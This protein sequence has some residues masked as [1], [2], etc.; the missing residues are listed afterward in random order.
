MRRYLPTFI[1]LF[2]LLVLGGLAVINNLGT[3]ITT[4]GAYVPTLSADPQTANLQAWIFALAL[5][6][7]VITTVGLGIFLAISFY[8]FTLLAARH[9]VAATVE[10]AAAPKS[11][12]GD[13]GLGIPLSNTRSV[14]VFWIVVAL[15]VVGFQALRVVSQPISLAP[16]GYIPSV[17][18]FGNIV[19]FRLPGTHI[20]GL[21]T[22]IAGPG[23][24]VTALHLF[25]AVLGLAI[26]GVAAV[27]FGLAQGFVR[28]DYTV[29]T[30]D[31]YKGTL[32]DKLLPLVEQRM[33]ALRAPRPKQL[34][35]N[36]IDSILISLNVLL[37]VVIAG[38]IAFYVVP[39][40]QGVSAVD[41]AIEATRVAGLQPPSPTAESGSG[42][43]TP[44]EIEQAAFDQLPAGDAAAGQTVFQG[45][46]GCSACH[47]LVADQTI[48][49]PSLAG[50][51]QR[52]PQREPGFT[53]EAYLYQSITNP[54]AFVVEGFQ[55]NIMPQTFKDTLGPQGLANVIAF[56]KTQ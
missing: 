56:L 50:V 51:S 8:R 43:S 32:P 42:G 29:R 37:F 7:I 3:P 10:R 39:S 5:G 4:R 35:G 1:L 38:I 15:L 44:A 47:S 21:P 52:G 45:A 28:L 25:I 16:L 13:T 6:G 18:A 48:V 27:G 24:N 54:N 34:P 17:G 22:F 14:A 53:E 40:Y 41:T 23:D 2:I 9:P 46:G 19:L 31:K 20:D 12:A 33:G 30:A 55:P 36:P 26:V 11:N 49:G